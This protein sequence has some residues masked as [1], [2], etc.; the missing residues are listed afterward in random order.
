VSSRSSAAIRLRTR[1]EGE[2]WLA[3]SGAASVVFAVLVM[4]NPSAGA[5]GLLWFIG[6]YAIA[7]GMI[8]IVLGFKVRRLRGRLKEAWVA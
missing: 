5:L 4:W 7:F 2:W 1:I 8:L 3:L 6:S